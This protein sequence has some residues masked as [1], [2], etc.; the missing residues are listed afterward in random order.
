VNLRLENIRLPLDRFTLSVDVAI[1]EDATGIFGAS[2]AGKTSLLDL[3]AGLR[4]AT[5]ARIQLDGEVLTDTARGVAIPTRRRR[6]GY[7]PQDLALFPHLSVRENLAYGFRAKP[8]PPTPFTVE[9]V[10]RVLEIAP[11]LDRGVNLLSGGEKQRV[12]LARALLA[13]PRLLLLDEPLASLDL[14]LKAR[15][16][17]YLKKV[18]DEFGVPMLYVT[19]SPDEVFALCNQV[20]VLE[21]GHFVAQGRP[22]DLFLATD[23]PNYI[24][25]PR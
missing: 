25:K 4:R 24:L 20:L 8:G 18:R 3:I 7:V 12:A 10:T 16:V 23:Q 6:L 19:H 11:L 5:S 1:H 13:A 21:E 15:I 22:A 17:P 14:S 2:G 9:H